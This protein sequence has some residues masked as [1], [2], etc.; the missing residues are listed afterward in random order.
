[1]DKGEGAYSNGSGNYIYLS[2]YLKNLIGSVF[3]LT[4]SIMT[5]LLKLKCKYGL[6]C[7]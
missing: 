6:I 1:M 5:Y 4:F 7:C 2:G 3:P